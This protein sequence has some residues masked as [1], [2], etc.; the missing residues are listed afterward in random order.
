MQLA[1]PDTR[2][3]A[4]DWPPALR[5]A[6]AAWAR[7]IAWGLRRED[8]P[9]A[10]ADVAT[11][12]GVALAAKLV[13]DEDQLVRVELTGALDALAVAALGVSD[14]TLDDV[15]HHRLVI[16]HTR[17]AVDLLDGLIALEPEEAL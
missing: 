8:A 17:V 3:Q 7:R 6:D 5:F 9:E 13:F 2:S 10:G 15:A 11:L 12:Q 16:G 14:A 4:V 1:P